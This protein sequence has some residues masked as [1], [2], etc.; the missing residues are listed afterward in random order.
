MTGVTQNRQENLILIL[1]QSTETLQ[2]KKTCEKQKVGNSCFII[3]SSGRLCF[4]VFPVLETLI[5]LGRCV[6]KR[7][8]PKIMHSVPCL[9][10]KE[11]V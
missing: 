11:S 8:Q 5:I 2:K 9:S 7:D 4:I 1:F 10:Y 6:V 3:H